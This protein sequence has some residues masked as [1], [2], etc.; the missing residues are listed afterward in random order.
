MRRAQHEALTMTIDIQS[1]ALTE[2]MA[3]SYSGMDGS[4][5]VLGDGVVTRL[6]NHTLSIQGD[7]PVTP[8][9]ELALMVAIPESDD[10]LC[11]VKTQ[12][13]SS[14]WN[15]FEVDLRQVPED[16]RA[17]L[18]CLLENFQAAPT[19]SYQVE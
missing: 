18:T 5:C 19:F 16:T 10:Y 17:Q 4:R 15:I 8:G 14:T 7:C 13:A 2:G 11:L 9:M 6:F 1:T 12:V 3:I